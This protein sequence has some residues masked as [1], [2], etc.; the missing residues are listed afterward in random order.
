M[1]AQGN[2]LDKLPNAEEGEVFE[3]LVK[4]QGLL[5]ERIVSRGQR[6]ALGQ[7]YEQAQNEWVILLRGAACLRWDDGTEV[8]LTEGDYALIPALKRHRVEWTDP[9]QETVWLAV[10]FAG[11]VAK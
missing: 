4:A 10:H 6:S 7:W 8:V 1:Q 2:F 5:I 9:K 3:A 11:T